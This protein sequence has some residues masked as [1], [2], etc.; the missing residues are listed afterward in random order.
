MKMIFNKVRLIPIFISL[1]VFLL[2]AVSCSHNPIKTNMFTGFQEI[3]KGE[4]AT[5]KWDFQ[6]ADRVRIEGIDVTFDSADSLTVSPTENT[7]YVITAYQ[8]NVDS[9][10]MSARIIIIDDTKGTE[11]ISETDDKKDD[12]RSDYLIAIKPIEGKT[13][14]NKAK[15]TR[16]IRRGDDGNI[17]IHSILIDDSGSFIRGAASE[18]DAKWWIELICEDSSFKNN[19]QSVKEYNN[20]DPTGLSI[21]VLLD[22]SASS[23]DNAT[24]I[25]SI[26]SIV[27]LMKINDKLKLAAFNQDHFNVFDYSNAEEA[28][29]QLE[30]LSFP[31][32]SGL[33]APYKAAYK[34]L[35][36]MTRISDRKKALVLV[37]YNSDNASIIYTPEDVIDIAYNAN[38]PVYIIAMGNAV[39]TYSYKYI[40]SMTGGKFYYLDNDSFQDFP[41]VLSEIILSQKYY[42]EYYLPINQIKNE[43]SKATSTFYFANDIS[44]AQDEQIIYLASE[45]QYSQYQA[46]CS[47]DFQS[48]SVSSTYLNTIRS[49]AGV[50]K[51]NPNIQIEL[52]GNSSN[53]G[54]QDHNLLLSQ[55]RAEEVRTILIS[56]GV[57]PEQIKTKGLGNNKP[58]YY[59]ES[60]DWQ[61]AYNRRVEIRWLDP[62]L[63]PYEIVAEFAKTETDAE[64]MSRKWE[65][66]GYRSYYD[67][68]LVE[69]LLVYRVKIWGFRT[70]K[71]AEKEAIKLS[72]QYEG[73][74]A[75]E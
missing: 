72:K 49:L 65:D 59:M 6:Y 8:G 55:A 40:A 17:T 22:N 64:I 19:I 43:C 71:D 69:N 36:N 44:S 3:R 57:K 53:E 16:M 4:N 9:L 73:Y 46:V 66:R 56:Y 28:Q 23:I 10:Q 45:P 63:L 50:L 29:W 67:R 13:I 54:D 42:Y 30:N 41:K 5:I 27:P 52:I 48:S 26:E 70:T 18:S 11:S 51:D 38:S 62:S 60:Y 24:T 2:I 74:F 68:Y 1:L 31:P 20:N 75:V 25:K 34:E 14:V 7:K 47:F 33:N 32:Q 61:T 37:V 35:E 15:V 39:S 12:D 58:V 21:A